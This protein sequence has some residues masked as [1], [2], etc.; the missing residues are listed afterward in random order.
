MS[1]EILNKVLEVFFAAFF[2]AGLTVGA[3]YLIRILSH[4]LFDK[5]N[6]EDEI[7]G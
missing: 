5:E 4:L 2:I 6:N 3:A 7:D 1:K